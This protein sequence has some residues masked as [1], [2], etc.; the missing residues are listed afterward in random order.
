MRS[1]R[2]F[3]F[4]RK[5]KK[6]DE[7]DDF[8]Y[9][10]YGRTTQLGRVSS[11]YFPVSQEEVGRKKR[12]MVVNLLLAMTLGAEEDKGYELSTSLLWDVSKGFDL[13][14]VIGEQFICKLSGKKF[15]SASYND[16]L[17]FILTT[18]YEEGHEFAINIYNTLMKRL[19][20]E[21]KCHLAY[22]GFDVQTRNWHFHEYKNCFVGKEAVTWMIKNGL[23]KSR[24]TA[25]MLGQRWL[26]NKL[27]KH[28]VD[29]RGFEDQKYYYVFEDTRLLF[30]N[31]NVN[32]LKSK[33]NH[34]KVTSMLL[35]PNDKEIKDMEYKD[36]KQ[37]QG[38]IISRYGTSEYSGFGN[39]GYN[40]SN[41][42][43]VNYGYNGSTPRLKETPS[44]SSRV[45][46]FSSG[47]QRVVDSGSPKKKTSYTLPTLFGGH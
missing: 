4:G 8:K 46:K 19:S 28:V 10:R 45:R 12:R 14:L 3:S 47:D 13:P 7:D 30:G 2:A 44:F 27:I 26:N 32:A 16:C 40:Q 11:T 33:G 29:D 42:M 17:Q 20:D 38:T 22:H 31:G 36:S 9:S 1:L 24:P 25:V 21:Q 5:K 43:N 18:L 37:H 35:D 39:F 41:D 34:R 6:E 15:Q 23:S